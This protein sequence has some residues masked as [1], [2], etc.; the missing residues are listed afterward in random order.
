VRL[1]VADN[2]SF[3]VDDCEVTREGPTYTVD[4]LRHLHEKR[5]E[6][7]LYFI[8]GQD[9]LAD[10]PAWHEPAAIAELATIAVAQRPGSRLS[11]ELPF[12]ADRLV[13]IDMPQLEI[14]A[15]ELR[16]RAAAGLSIRYLM[17]PAVADYI[18]GN[19]LYSSG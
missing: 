16:Q 19:R 10:M 9:A 14:S 8:L 13:R 17:P 5:P 7:E 2:P 1:A 3:S 15:T 4:T 6:D 12:A 11:V 18:R